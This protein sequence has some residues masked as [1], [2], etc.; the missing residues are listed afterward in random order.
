VSLALCLPALQA[1]TPK[2]TVC[3][4]T[5]NSADEKEV[6]RRYLPE[7]KFQFIELVERGRADWL[8]AACRAAV[9]CD[10]LIIS[11]HF[12][13]HN[14]FFSDEL[15]TH[16]SLPVD[17]LE[18]VSC[19]D[20]CRS[21]FAKLRE[22]HLYGCNTLNVEPQTRATAE[23]VRSLVREGRSLKQAEQRMRTL[24]A[25]HG[26]SSRDRMRQVFKG[27]PVIYGFSSVAPLGPIAGASLV[28]YFKVHGTQEIARGRPSAGLLAQFTP[29]GMSVAA[30]LTDTDP[31][32]AVREDVCHFVDERLTEGKRLDFVHQLM[33]REM[34]QSRIHLDRISRYTATLGEP[35]RQT[36]QVRQGL[37][38]IASDTAARQRYLDFARDADQPVVRARM[39]KVAHELGWLTDEERWDELALLLAELQARNVV[40]V[41]EVDLACALNETHDLDGAYPQ[42]AGPGGAADDLPHAAVRACLGSSE[43]HERTVTALLSQNEA[44]ARIA[45]DYLRHR[46]IADIGVLRRVAAGIVRMPPSQAQVNAL[47]ALGRHYLSDGEILSLLLDLFAQTASAPVQ[48]AIAGILIRADRRSLASPQLVQT[49]Q[50]NRKPSAPGDNIIDALLRRLQTP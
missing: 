50:R 43:D 24:N 16:E 45:R 48:T 14:E 32:A 10:V 41:A 12:D 8:A 22:V 6:F 49:L 7:S 23:I 2:Q 25:G 36:A 20:S 38:A 26:E 9:S 27:V 46:P 42:R 5:V 17:E 1:A 28:S 15:G 30:G 13:G 40:G 39:L 47:A 37:A 33:Q 19:S 11:G 35:A 44:D 3:T 31:Q 18:R 34:A 21:L 29:Y 4:I